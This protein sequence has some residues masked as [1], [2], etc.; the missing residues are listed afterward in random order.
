VLQPLGKDTAARIQGVGDAGFD[1]LD[2]NVRRFIAAKRALRLCLQAFILVALGFAA[3]LRVPEVDGQSMMPGIR[4]GTHVLI[5]TLA[6]SFGQPIRRGD[7]VAFR[8]SQDRRVLLKRVIALAGE[9]I[10]ITD[11]QVM[12]N[13]VAPNASFATFPDR[14]EMSPLVVPSGSVFVLGDNR[15]Q[16]VDSRSFGPVR[17]SAIIGKA[18]LVIWPVNQIRIAR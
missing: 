18:V 1:L 3:F 2:K 15:A 16:S 11:G 10:S 4:D 13:G 9:K 5:N 14:S 8:D 6:Y 7:L 12:V 17:D